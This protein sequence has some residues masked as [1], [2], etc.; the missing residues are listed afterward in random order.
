MQQLVGVKRDASQTVAVDI[1]RF[2]C[3]EDDQLLLIAAKPRITE[4]SMSEK[5]QRI[6][7]NEV[8]ELSYSVEDGPV[9]VST[10]TRG[11]LLDVD[12]RDLK[13]TLHKRI[14]KPSGRTALD[15]LAK[16]LRTH[17][18]TKDLPTDKSLIT[19]IE[20]DWGYVPEEHGIVADED[21]WLGIARDC[22]QPLSEDRLAA[23]LLHA[24]VRLLTRF[25][26]DDLSDIFRAMY[27]YR[28]HSAAGEINELAVEGKASRDNRAKGSQAKKSKGELQRQL[29]LSIAR[30]FWNQNPKL[31]GQ[32]RNT[33]KKIEKAV[34]D[35]RK[36]QGIGREPLAVKTISDQLRLALR[37]A[38]AQP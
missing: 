25:N 32:N 26:D 16:R 15:A 7:L 28:L 23:E 37:E 38:G 21:L 20:R 9:V 11:F 8:K 1:C 6:P 17:L 36:K 35:E 14:F 13:D 12:V 4:A 30:E 10:R 29:I 2:A 22:T 3:L 5:Q 24:I 19:P 33:A 18:D 34:N 27:M 31:N